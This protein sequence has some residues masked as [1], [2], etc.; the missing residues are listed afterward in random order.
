MGDVQTPDPVDAVLDVLRRS[1]A[2]LSCAEI[3]KALMASGRDKSHV[4]DL[5]KHAQKKVSGHREVSY[6]TSTKRY[7]WVEP[8]AISATEAF[9][10]LIRGRVPAAEKAALTEVVRAA[11]PTA[12]P[13]DGVALARQRQAEIDFAR[14]L[15]ELAIEVEEL[16]ANQAPPDVLI[17]RVR[18]RVHRNG[19]EPIDRAGEETTFDRKRH[20]AIGG[21]IRDGAP[22]VVVRPGYVWKAAEEDVLIGKAVVEE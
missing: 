9:E 14:N 16:T 8:A 7:S 12:V 21:S 4:D 11:L 10:R 5:W 6:D 20:R 15:A 13:P 2:A 22:V 17:H 18:A 19:L 1:T 3:K